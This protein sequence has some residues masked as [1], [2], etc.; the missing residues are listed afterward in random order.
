MLEQTLKVHQLCEI[1]KPSLPCNPVAETPTTS[2]SQIVNRFGERLTACD[3][4]FP[5]DANSGDQARTEENRRKGY[6]AEPT[7]V[8][9]KMLGILKIAA[10][11]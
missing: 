8:N 6:L 4:C 2:C 5:R 11:I 1:E 10:D 3:I 9:V 7:T